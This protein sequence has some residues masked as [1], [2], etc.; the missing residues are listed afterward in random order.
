[1]PKVTFLSTNTRTGEQEVEGE[2]RLE[3]GKLVASG[4]LAEHIAARPLEVED[5]GRFV[6]IDPA[7]EPERFL[8]NLARHYNGSYLRATR[9]TE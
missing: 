7:K 9:V 3:G 4:T 2:I 8:E 5:A 1:M 6:L